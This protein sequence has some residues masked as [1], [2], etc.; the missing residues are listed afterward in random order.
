MKIIKSLV[1]WVPRS[2][3]VSMCFDRLVIN[4]R[5]PEN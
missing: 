2:S 5:A 4:S 1:K 3:I